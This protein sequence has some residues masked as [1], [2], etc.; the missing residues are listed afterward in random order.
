MSSDTQAFWEKHAKAYKTAF[1]K[2]DEVA[3]YLERSETRHLFHVLDVRPQMRV[4]DLACGTGRWAFEFARRCR[5]VVA[6]D[7]AAGMIERAR[8]EASRR[9]VGNVEFRV[10]SIEQFQ[11][12]ETFDI[13]VLSGILVYFSDQQ[14]DAILQRLR[15]TLKPGAKIVSRETVAIH[16][17]QDVRQEAHAKVGDTY[18]A[19][20]RRP[21]EYQQLFARHGFRLE[22]R[23]DFVPTNFPMIIYRRFVPA[24]LRQHALVRAGLRLALKLQYAIDP[25]LL[26]FPALYRPIMKRFWKIKSMLFIYGI[27]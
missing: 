18:S 26:K 21:E 22:Y 11:A 12:D 19:I 17:R 10:G 14:V 23:H 1:E 6:I 8:Q 24:T 20:Y 25:L 5:R 27:D 3:E 15:P 9:Q 13:L 16:E 7:F 2:L 4:L